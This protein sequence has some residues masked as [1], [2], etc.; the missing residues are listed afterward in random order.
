MAI[1][2]GR[3]ACLAHQITVATVKLACQKSLL[4]QNLVFF[5]LLDLVQVVKE[6]ECVLGPVL[7][8]GKDIASDA[9]GARDRQLLVSEENI[10]DA[11]FHLNGVLNPSLL[12]E[13]VFEALI[14]F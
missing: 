10:N 13:V 2:L 3:I 12:L 8:A 4:A 1:N 9:C 5:G 7:C 6:H 11:V 14:L